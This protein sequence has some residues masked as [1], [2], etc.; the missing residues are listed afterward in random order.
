MRLA[1]KT[2]A[3]KAKAAVVNVE[4]APAFDARQRRTEAGDVHDSS[5][6]AF[7]SRYRPDSA[8]SQIRRLCD[9]EATQNTQST[10]TT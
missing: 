8:D 7:R 6:T 4:R 2:T 3:K 5:L 10:H 1:K 9:E